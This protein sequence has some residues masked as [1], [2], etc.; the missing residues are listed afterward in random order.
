MNLPG[1]FRK[2]LLNCA[3]A[4]LLSI[5]LSNTFKGIA[6]VNNLEEP[7]PKVV[8]QEPSRLIIRNVLQFQTLASTTTIKIPP[9]GSKSKVPVVL[10]VR[11]KNIA[12]VGIRISWFNTLKPYFETAD[13]RVVAS[14]SGTDC[15][16]AREVSNYPIVSPGESVDYLMRGVFVWVDNSLYLKI[17]DGCDFYHF[18]DLSPGSY[19]FLFFYRN[20]LPSTETSK[21]GI[22]IDYIWTGEIRFCRKFHVRINYPYHYHPFSL[23][24]QRLLQ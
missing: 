16:A 17:K 21:E 3:T 14:A 2:S 7:I 1:I 10:G 15:L 22:R 12:K 23:R 24:F 20:Q 9:Q 6:E 13:G 11:V 8:E 4:L 5:S 18:Q 19:R